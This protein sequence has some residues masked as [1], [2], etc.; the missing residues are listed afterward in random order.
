MK[1]RPASVLLL[2][3]ATL[4]AGEGDA[5]PGPAKPQP[6]PVPAPPDLLGWS[7]LA[8][9]GAFLT[10]AYASDDHANA[11]DPAIRGASSSIA[12]RF[13][14]DA[15]LAWRG[16]TTAVDQ[17]L[18]AA[19]GRL[20][21]QGA[22]WAESMD[23]LRYD[24][25]FR[26]DIVRPAFVYR[27][28]GAETVFTAPAPDGD[29]FDP[30]RV[31]GSWGV[32]QLFKDLLAR[33]DALEW[34]LGV[35]IQKSWG[36]LPPPREELLVGPEALL[37]YERQITKE[38]RLF[39]MYE[40]WGDFEDMRHLTHVVTAGLSARIATHVTAELALRAYREER[41]RDAGADDPGYDRWHVRQDT[42]VGLT[43]TF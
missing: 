32:G 11:P 41:P 7:H 5:P 35:R 23:E 21:Q 14:L 30:L 2:A 10:T 33:S 25:V 24:G 22:A 37:R 4:G 6:P 39:V 12:Y 26:R 29:A 17:R 36:S 13:Q 43:A 28:W 34:R 31:H 16:D 8:N 3:A 18:R 42:L 1:C 40:G 15:A 20:R 38:N 9:V 19:Y 27:A